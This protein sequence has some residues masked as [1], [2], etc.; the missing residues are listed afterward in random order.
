MIDTATSG[1]YAGPWI[2]VDLD[3]TLAEYHG[4]QGVDHIGAPIAAMVERVKV[5]IKQGQNVRIF[6]ARVGPHDT[7]YADGTPIDA[8]FIPKA[9]AAV[10]TWCLK[11][12]GVV[13]PVT[14][15]KDF[16]MIHLYDDRC[17]Q[18]ELNT[19]RLVA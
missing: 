9:R 15:T 6:T 11:H 18:V 3:G 19:G 12:L 8:D 14:A 7:H 1:A 10:E 17:T 16:G 13:L 4:W 5:W 2:G